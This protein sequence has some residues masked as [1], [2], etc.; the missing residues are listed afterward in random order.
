MEFSEFISN[1][2]TRP[3]EGRLAL[4][5]EMGNE[6]IELMR[7][8]QNEKALQQL[9]LELPHQD[10]AQVIDILDLDFIYQSIKNAEQ[11]SRFL[12]AF[13]DP[14]AIDLLGYFYWSGEGDE[15]FYEIIHDF[16]SLTMV[17][18]ALSEA[19][20]AVLLE[21]V[22]LDLIQDYN[23]LNIVLQHLSAEACGILLNNMRYTLADMME[24]A[25]CDDIMNIVKSAPAGQR[26]EV[27]INMDLPFYSQILSQFS[28]RQLKS[29][30][31]KP[32]H[33]IIAIQGL[34]NG[35]LTGF[36]ET[37]NHADFYRSI[38]QDEQDLGLVMSSIMS[39]AP[40]LPHF[41]DAIRS[42]F[43][44]YVQDAKQLSRLAHFSETQTSQ[45]REYY[46]FPAPILSPQPVPPHHPAAILLN[47]SSEQE[48]GLSSVQIKP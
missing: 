23:Q 41:L 29:S 10:R 38:I 6:L 15:V 16:E 44:E 35:Q 34:D 39:I 26:L 28:H 4:I 36:L 11:L 33:L 5:D 18:R 24:G 32:E 43:N 48:T 3:L 1:L 13:P 7:A 17:M 21:Y 14:E 12:E 19:N 47:W 9:F 8:N 22:N 31:A 2:G 25:D 45:I 37:I 30:I 46:N 42:I 40:N 27:L 20:R